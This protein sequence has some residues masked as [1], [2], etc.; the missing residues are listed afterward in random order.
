MQSRAQTQTSYGFPKADTSAALAS[1]Q[2]IARRHR[3]GARRLHDD[4]S[5]DVAVTEK[6]TLRLYL[7]CFRR[8]AGARRI[9]PAP[10]HRTPGK[11]SLAIGLALV[12][13]A[14]ATT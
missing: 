14:V 4:G 6:G 7:V 10:W 1:A 2:E 9:D 3:G 13:A 12:A 11:I 8:D 5:I